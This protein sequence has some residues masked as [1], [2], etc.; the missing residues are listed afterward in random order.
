MEALIGSWPVVT[1]RFRPT[2]R[3]SHCLNFLM[4]PL[5]HCLEC[6]HRPNL[7][8]IRSSNQVGRHRRGCLLPRGGQGC[9]HC[10]VDSN[11]HHCLFPDQ[12][13][14]WNYHSAHHHVLFHLLNSD[15]WSV[16]SWARF[17]S[18]SRRHLLLESELQL[19]CLAVLLLAG[20]LGL[21]L[22]PST[23][24]MPSRTAVWKHSGWH[25][26]LLRCLYC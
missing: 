4:S 11:R 12:N 17:W 25:Q 2:H 5:G 19:Y 23:R 18:T 22:R 14:H 13:H 10:S 21:D 3:Y 1:S 16:R 7:G 26:C 20:T 24:Q 15:Y 9:Y 8:Q 6:F